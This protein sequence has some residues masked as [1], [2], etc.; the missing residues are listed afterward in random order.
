[1]DRMHVEQHQMRTYAPEELEAMRYERVA[2]LW[3][4]WG[5]AKGIVYPWGVQETW[6][7]IRELVDNQLGIEYASTEELEVLLAPPPP[8]TVISSENL[9][10]TITLISLADKDE[11]WSSLSG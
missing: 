5:D 10:N 1:M 2:I 4:R 3:A 9:S 11:D 6:L 8:P 7:C